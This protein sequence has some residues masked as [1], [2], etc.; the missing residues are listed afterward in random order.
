MNKVQIPAFVISQCINDTYK[1]DARK[2]LGNLILNNITQKLSDSLIV[3]YG[4]ID[5]PINYHITLSVFIKFI[6]SG[7][8]DIINSLVGIMVNTFI[9]DVQ[10]HEY[11]RFNI[12]SMT[13]KLEDIAD[14][15]KF[16]LNINY[17]KY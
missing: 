15:L 4:D 16:T 8:T 1:L 6:S 13:L 7:R 10:I 11:E 3:E 2:C 5:N 9:D 12:C 14:E 17:M